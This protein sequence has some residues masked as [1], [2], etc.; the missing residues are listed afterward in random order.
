M[1]V[2][3][4]CTAAAVVA[5]ANADLAQ[6][7]GR[8]YCYAYPPLKQMPY[9]GMTSYY[10]CA[11]EVVRVIHQAS[12]F[13]LRTVVPEWATVTGLVNYARRAGWQQFAPSALAGG[14]MVAFGRNGSWYHVGIGRALAHGDTA[15]TIEG[16]TSS[17]NFPGS[18]S[19]GGVLATR[20][21]SIRAQ[22]TGGYFMQ[23]WRPPYKPATTSQSPSPKP[24]GPA[25][26]VLSFGST[27]NDVARLQA[28]LRR[29]FPAYA[30]ALVAD[31][32]FGRLTLAAVLEFQRRSGLA[33]DG[34]VGP[35]TRAKLATYGVTF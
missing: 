10:W 26:R 7:G 30:G 13:D 18:D 16:D 2:Q 6:Y 1:T 11:A 25:D 17:P 35:I 20:D 32:S 33:P 12:G 29:A 27:G 5:A 8:Q 14:D 22:T 9:Q 28:G 34:H 19:T 4:P 15:P 23:V 24:Q 21:R 31:G 3:I